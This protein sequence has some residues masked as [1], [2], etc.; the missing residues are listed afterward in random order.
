MISDKNTRVI[1]DK[2]VMVPMRDG[3]KLATD[4]YRPRDEKPLP[5]LFV[6]LPYNKDR[7]TVLAFPLDRFLQAGYAIVLQDM[8][9]RYASE[10]T[11]TLTENE[12]SD[13][14]DTIDW[15]TQQ[16]WSDGHVGMFGASYLGIPQWLVAKEQP[17]ALQALAPMH[18]RH[19]L[20]SHQGGAFELGLWFNW[21]LMQGGG[22][23]VRR[24][25]ARGQAEQGDLDIIA[26]AEQEIQSLY[27]H[28]PLLDV[29]L[30]ENLS[31]YYFDWLAHGTDEPARHLSAQSELYGK[32]TVPALNIGGWYDMFLDGAF[33]NYQQM[34]KW[35]GSE[36]ARTFQ[37]LLIGPWAHFDLPGI[38]PERDYG[39][40]ASTSGVDLVGIHL[41]WF[42]H[43]LKGI[44]NGVEQEKPVHL[45]VMGADIWRSEEDWPLPDA[46]YRDFYLHS[47]GRA[48][49]A[50][51]DGVLSVEAPDEEPADR[52]CYDPR[53][54]VPTIGGA[55]LL[56]IE[57]GVAMM[58]NKPRTSPYLFQCGPRDQREIEQ[59][60][61]VLCYTTEPLAQPIEV[62]GPIELVLSVSSSALDTD[63]TGKLVDVFPDGRAEI[64]TDSILRARYR[65]S[66]ST[67]ALLEPEK[68]YELRFSLGAT[69]NVFKAGHCIRLEVSSSNFPRFN[70]NT[71]T[72]GNI[73]EERE[74]DLIQAINQ[75]YHNKAHPSYIILPIIEREG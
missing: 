37:H 17:A 5:V 9:G 58:S 49:T 26:K 55:N 1:L 11:F 28:L 64:L 32:I 7:P 67:P 21:A 52:Y 41:R 42:D 68:I 22:G 59:R 18:T 20:Y 65:N 63:F 43:W 44:E 71:N 73:I 47:Q 19:S 46:R 61:D 23:E 2:N 27:S 10:G 57:G 14:V 36:A 50:S 25:I 33:E 12:P 60:D 66:L 70:R 56:P 40:S 31:P 24:R 6:R 39:P 62:T 72:G 38:F 30:F 34:K 45:F 54:P 69:A 35:G 51:G 29:P 16:P 15:I 48:N 75:V 3:V 8:R 13:G 4:V 53:N 74:E